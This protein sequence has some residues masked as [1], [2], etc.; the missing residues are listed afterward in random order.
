[1]NI[2]LDDVLNVK[3]PEDFEWSPNGKYL[4]FLWDDGGRKDL[5]IVSMKDKKPKKLTD[6]GKVSSPNWSP[7]SKSMLY[8]DGDIWKVDLNGKTTQLIKTT[9]KSNMPT[10]S[11]DGTK[12]ALI[13]AE[14]LWVYSFEQGLVQ[15][16]D[17]KKVIAQQKGDILWSSEGEKIAFSFLKNRRRC[18]GIVSA[19]D[20]KTLWE[21]RGEGHRF[22]VAWL[23]KNEIIL[24]RRLNGKIREYLLLSLNEGKENLLVREEDERGLAFWD[25]PV[26]SPDGA[27]LVF[28][29]N[30]D[31][32]DHLWLI[33]LDKGEPRQ[34]TGGECED[35]GHALDSP[36]WSPDGAKIAFS[37][38]RGSLG[39][40]QIWTVTLDGSLEKVTDPKGSNVF[41]KWSPDGK[42]IAFIH[43]GPCESPDI[44]MVNPEEK[45]PIQ[46]T[47]SM[48]QSFKENATLPEEVSYKSSDL[49]VYAYLFRPSHK[50]KCPAI[51]WLHGGPIRQMRYGWHPT[52]AYSIF[53]AFHQYLLQKGYV[54]LSIN[55]RG[56]TGYGKRYEQ[57][58]YLSIGEGDVIDV[59]NG[60]KYLSSLDFVDQSRIGVWGIS[61]GGFLTLQLL[62]K[63]PDAF[64]VG[65]NIAGVSNWA[66][67][68]DWYEER[69]PE[70]VDFFK[71]RLGKDYE[72]ASP[73]SF[74]KDI[75]APIFNFHGTA[76][77]AV[78]FSQLDELIDKLVEHEKYFEVTY[79]P[80][81]SHLFR[82]RRTWKDTF[83]RIER[84]FERY[85]KS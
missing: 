52:R 48:P 8:Q 37:S 12:F 85:L 80:G 67:L 42:H 40:R 28:I 49:K 81:E 51:I 21:S 65:I 23:T 64:K 6:L 61:Y 7:D 63:Y 25:S 58:N 47:S 71:V 4:S 36:S 77:E 18:I 56:G 68:M 39:E 55:Y 59:I 62:G 26:L 17:N 76:D 35:I 43:S 84:C 83:R 32:W 66:S 20:G 10:W 45:K 41:P 70:T 31:G 24:K 75:K 60:V 34:L 30:K 2:T 53:Y 19:E 54:V 74:V 72:R 22:N 82:E 3:Y 38:N 46:L 14:D 33:S 27:N 16:T 1:M 29:S 50:K 9:A 11:P 5:W 44:W 13:M 57:G 15:L 69:H 73:I 79:Y 78:P